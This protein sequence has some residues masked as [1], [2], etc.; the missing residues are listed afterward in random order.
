[1]LYEVITILSKQPN[2]TVTQLTGGHNFGKQYS[3]VSKQILT[4]L[5]SAI[6]PKKAQ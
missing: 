1:M 3:L 4:S 5:A 2:V 6:A